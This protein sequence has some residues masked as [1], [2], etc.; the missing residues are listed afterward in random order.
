MRGASRAAYPPPAP[1]KR[2]GSLPAPPR[3]SAVANRMGQ[4]ELRIL[5]LKLCMVMEPMLLLYW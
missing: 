5:R 4:N 1:K 3:W 2:G